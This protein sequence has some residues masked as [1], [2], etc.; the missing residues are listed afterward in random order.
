MSRKQYEKHYKNITENNMDGIPDF[1]QF[2]QD[3]PLQYDENGFVWGFTTKEHGDGRLDETITKLLEELKIKPKTTV[4]LEQTHGTKIQFFEETKEETVKLP[5]SD[6][7]ITK[8]NGTFLTV[9]TADCV[10]L[11]FIDRKNKV[12]G[13][14]HQGWKGSLDRM[15]Q[16]MV[17]KMVEAGAEKEAIQVYV[18]PSIG[19]CCYNVEKD[20]YLKFKEEFYTYHHLFTKHDGEKYFLNLAELN[21]QQLLEAGLG[22]GNVNNL[23]KCTS[24]DAKTF[25]SYRR[26]SKEEFGEMIAYIIMK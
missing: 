17:D 10:P 21:V 1:S 5:D 2:T 20:R 13:V 4:R 7:V 15:G 14:S 16:K 9:L 11:I 3:Q 22:W 19:M 12:I 8:L 24:C 23:S 25:Y 26:D 6:G 18:G